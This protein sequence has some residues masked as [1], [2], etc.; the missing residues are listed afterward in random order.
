MQTEALKYPWLKISDMHCCVFW[1]MPST[2]KTE[3]A[4]SPK[5]TDIR[6]T[7]DV[8]LHPRRSYFWNSLL[9]GTQSHMYMNVTCKVFSHELKYFATTHIL[10]FNLYTMFQFNFFLRTG[11]Y[12]QHGWDETHR[13]VFCLHVWLNHTPLFP[14]ETVF[15][16]V[17]F[18]TEE[19]MHIRYHRLWA[20]DQEWNLCLTSVRIHTDIGCGV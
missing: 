5:S 9:W 11:N 19:V 10:Y 7:K 14:R 18:L 3:E 4:G 8:V 13:T 20:N 12:E 16:A 1:R 17:I 6:L 2:L 15:Y